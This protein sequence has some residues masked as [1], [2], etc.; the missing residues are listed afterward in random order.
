M[1]AA[2]KLEKAHK[3]HPDNASL[4]YAYAAALYLTPLAT[5]RAEEQMKQLAK[6]HPDFHQAQ[7]ALM[8]MN[9]R[10]WSGN[11]FTLPP[12]SP[13]ISAVHPKI[14]RHVKGTTLFTVRD[15]I[16]PKVAFFLRDVDRD[17]RDRS[18]LES[19]RIELATIISPV[20]TDH[21]QVIG[22]YARITPKQGKPI[23]FEALG[24][25]ELR[26]KDMARQGYQFFCTQRE[27]DFVVLNSQGR[28]LFNKRLP[29]SQKMRNTNER[30]RK[31]LEKP[32]EQAFSSTEFFK[33]LK[34]HQRGFSFADV[35]Y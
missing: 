15:H 30:L 6:T 35:D 14:A 16:E 21:Y 3:L 25:V 19:A 2:R 29:I 12:W 1:E 32:S 24:V 18:V 13:D 9:T 4:R 20:A 31:L 34:A 7:F 17:F 11:L 22:V 26:Q 28:I 5:S 23:E 27:I 8:G 10:W 33:A